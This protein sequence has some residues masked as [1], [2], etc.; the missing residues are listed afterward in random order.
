MNVNQE[1]KSKLIE[2]QASVQLLKTSLHAKNQGNAVKFD[3]D[4]MSER[5]QKLLT[6]YKGELKLPSSPLVFTDHCLNKL[7][8]MMTDEDKIL[9]GVKKWGKKKDHWIDS[10]GI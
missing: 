2:F 1:G 9:K 4:I 7:I 8:R 5:H 6:K 10:E 3:S